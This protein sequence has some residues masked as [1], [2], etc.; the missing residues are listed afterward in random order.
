MKKLMAFALLLAVVSVQA[1]NI[2][3][4]AAG[5][6]RKSITNVPSG[7]LVVL[8]ER[9]NQTWPSS[10][11][12]EALSVIKT[13]AAKKVI[14][15]DTERTVVNDATNGYVEVSD[16]G[17]D[18]EFMS[19]CVWRR[20]NG[21]RLLAVNIGKPA[22]PDMEF[23][24]LYDYDPQRKTLT[25][26]PDILADFQYEHNDS[27]LSYT[28]PRTGKEL[29]IVE[30]SEADPDFKREHIFSWDGMKPVLKSSTPVKEEMDGG[31]P[32][33][34]FVV[35]YKGSSPTIT[36]FIDALLT[37]EPD[38]A[39]DCDN[40]EGTWER[41]RQGLHEMEGE[42]WTID[43]RNG[44]VRL[45][46]WYEGYT[47]VYREFCFWNCTDGRHKLFAMNSGIAQDGR[48]NETECT[49]LRLYSYDNATRLL[50]YVGW[51]TNAL[52]I[53]EG[54]PLPIFSRLPRTG[55]NLEWS[56]NDGQ[57]GVLKWNGRSWN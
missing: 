37:D 31:G 15:E 9:F 30:W 34:T 53:D 49:G 54:L 21:H 12:G 57:R 46:T 17:T 52:G 33:F 28:L 39:S 1:Q 5:W 11:V 38:E 48:E 44:Y 2:G 20:S 8:L 19:A 13:G 45:A 40:W 7:S 47:V 55:K 18:A 10:S 3:N 51:G 35:S 41:C 22:D 43:Q 6:Q 36:D 24:C 25:P 29:K 26:E 42:E 56:T 27:R 50:K 23:L 14:D 16:A 4:I 32:D